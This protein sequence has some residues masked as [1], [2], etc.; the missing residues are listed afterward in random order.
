MEMSTSPNQGAAPN[1]RLR[2]GLVPWSFEFSK[3]SGLG[4][5]WADRSA[6]RGRAVGRE[7]FLPLAFLCDLGGL[8]V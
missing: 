8:G 1:R 4:G 5:R 7:D 6:P 3:K 2:L